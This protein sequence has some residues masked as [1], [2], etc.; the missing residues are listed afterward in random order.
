VTSGAR[1]RAAH[2]VVA[3]LAVAGTFTWVALPRAGDAAAP[4]VGPEL[5]EEALASDVPDRA[6]G[7][8]DIEHFEA[9]LAERGE[10]A[11]SRSW[12]VGAYLSRFRAYGE[13]ADLGAAQMHLEGLPRSGAGANEVASAASALHLARH[14]FRGALRTARETA[15]RSLWSDEAAAFRLFDALWAAGL[16]EH[17]AE[18]LE[19][20]LDTTTVGYLSREARVL[21]RMGRVAEARDRFRAIVERVDA[22]AEPASVRGWALVEAGNFEL[23]SGDA[24]AAVARYREALAVLPGSPAALE[25]LASVAYGVDR[26]LDAAAQLYR[27]ALENGAHLDLMPLLATIERERGNAAAAAQI[28]ATFQQT[29]LSD[30]LHERWFRRPLALMLAGRSK[31]VC[32]AVVLAYDDLAERRDPGAKDAMAWALYHAGDLAGAAAWAAEAVSRGVPEPLIAYHAGVIALAS[33]ERR[34]GRRLLE[35]ALAGQVELTV[36]EVAHTRALL[37]GERAA[38]PPVVRCGSEESN[39]R[40]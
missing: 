14:E 9:R 16:E 11:F 19:R 37:A 23:H 40:K 36:G 32:R 30:P 18:V 8:D 26:D 6:T 33:G 27:G 22:F 21:D 3:A 10:E 38:Q 12:L 24:A 28:E 34:Q 15:R 39:A 29:V 31:T 2:G 1:L 5:L 25:G 20:P 7:S 13:R 17:A 4:H 35:A